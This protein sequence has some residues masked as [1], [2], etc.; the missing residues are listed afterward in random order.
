M[1]LGEAP[2]TLT[3]VTL[4]SIPIFTLS[5]TQIVSLPDFTCTFTLLNSLLLSFGL[6]NPLTYAHIDSFLPLSFE[7]TLTRARTLLTYVHVYSFISTSSS[8]GLTLVTL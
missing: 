8:F 1:L 4:H 7:F 5:E 6:S 3:L 2:L